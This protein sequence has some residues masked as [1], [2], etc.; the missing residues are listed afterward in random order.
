MNKWILF[1]EIAVSTLQFEQNVMR[2]KLKSFSDKCVRSFQQEPFYLQILADGRTW[3]SN[4]I[5]GFTWDVIIHPYPKFNRD[6]LTKPSL[7]LGMHE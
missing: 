2:L 1:S 7:N 3:M 5:H 4:H 6:V